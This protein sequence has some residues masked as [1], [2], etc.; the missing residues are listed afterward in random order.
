LGNRDSLAETS[1]LDSIAPSFL[2]NM[3][4]NKRAFSPAKKKTALLYS[5]KA[6][7]RRL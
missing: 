3:Y 5:Y 6:P 2:L 4:S 1:D 7:K